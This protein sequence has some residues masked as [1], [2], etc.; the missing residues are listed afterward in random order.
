M[1]LMNLSTGPR[2]RDK[3]YGRKRLVPLATSDANRSLFAGNDPSL[4]LEKAVAKLSIKEA[5][6]SIQTQRSAAALNDNQ[7]QEERLPGRCDKQ[8]HDEPPQDVSFAPDED[9]V[10]VSKPVVE[11]KVALSK[12]ERAVLKPVMAF[13]RVASFARDFSAFG[14]QLTKEFDVRKLN[15]GSYSDCFV[16]RKPNE[17]VETA[18]LK[19]IPLECNGRAS[20]GAASRA[21]DFLREVKLLAALE[22]FHGFAQIF[23]SR[24][25]RGRMH[26]QMIQ[27]ARDWLETTQEDVDKTI[28][29]GSRYPED[30]IYGVI[31]MAYAGTD[32]DLLEKPSAFQAFDVFWMVAILLAKAEKEIEFEHRDLHMSNICFRPGNEGTV[33]VSTGFV[34]DMRKNPSKVL[35]LSG[36]RVSIID[37]THSRM[38]DAKTGEILYNPE[39]PFTAEEMASYKR[40]RR[41]CDQLD[42]IVKAQQWMSQSHQIQKDGAAKYE[43]FTP[44]TNVIWLSNVLYE[45]TKTAGSKKKRCHVPGSS[46]TAKDLQDDLWNKLAKT[47]KWIGS[48][49]LHSLPESAERF[50]N[51]AMDLGLIAKPDVDAFMESLNIDASPAG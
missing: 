44:K 48:P 40:E 31:E 42:T 9:V 37:Y 13:H 22:D 38:R 32:L 1:A 10:T 11:R 36:L 49:D 28:D 51:E 15:E 8:E 2:Q 18:V 46:A 41:P 16:V 23:R 27:A 45:L 30:Q 6:D 29:P 17:D 39:C 47:L 7:Y 24:I 33:D 43:T 20:S 3:V 14:S 35:G 34:Q 12:E 5:H 21:Y 19:I 50:L 26:D 25:V 4:S